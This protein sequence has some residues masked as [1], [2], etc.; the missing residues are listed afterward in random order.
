MYVTSTGSFLHLSQWSRRNLLD[1]LTGENRAR[2]LTMHCENM[3]VAFWTFNTS[4]QNHLMAIDVGKILVQPL[5]SISEE[6]F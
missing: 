1:R 4:T 2:H 5:R 3:I 6:L